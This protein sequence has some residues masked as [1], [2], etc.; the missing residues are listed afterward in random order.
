MKEPEQSSRESC[1]Q[2]DLMNSRFLWVVLAAIA[3]TPAFAISDSQLVQACQNT[4]S[5]AGHA[6]YE[7][8]KWKVVH[9]D[10]SNIA[11]TGQAAKEGKLIEFSCIFD[12]EFN[13]KDTA[14]NPLAGGGSPT[15]TDSSGAMVA[16]DSGKVVS[17]GDMV[18]F[19]KEEAANELGRNPADVKMGKAVKDA[20]WTV[21][22]STDEGKF[23]CRYDAK[24][25][26]VGVDEVGN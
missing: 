20:G 14:T 7:F 24:R 3:S 21:P 8:R 23:A 11:V 1:H 10:A 2:W 16:P 17:E 15:V 18:A 4:I 12:S 26:F 6:D 22:G 9:P 5:K 13:I 25:R 19:C